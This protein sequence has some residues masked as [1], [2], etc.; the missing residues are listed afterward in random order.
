M[1]HCNNITLLSPAQLNALADS[2]HQYH[3]YLADTLPVISAA[4]DLI[5]CYETTAGPMFL[6]MATTGGYPNTPGP[7]MDLNMTGRFLQ[8]NRNYLKPCIP[9]IKLLNTVPIFKAGSI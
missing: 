2:I 7:L 5:D 6:N 1:N 9:K 3:F 8:Y 4:F